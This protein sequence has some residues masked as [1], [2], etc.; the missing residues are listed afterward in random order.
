M[1][2]K[3]LSSLWEDW[4]TNK[5]G[6][7]I[8]TA[9][10]GVFTAVLLLLQIFFLK[11]DFDP[12][13]QMY[14]SS[15]TMPLLCGICFGGIALL[16]ATLLFPKGKFPFAEDSV[17]SHASVRA[18]NMA[19]ALACLFVAIR[20]FGN[21]S[22]LFD[23]MPVCILTQLM[24]LGSSVYFFLE[25]RKKEP[26]LVLRVVLGF[27]VI[28]MTALRVFSLYFDQS[29]PVLAPM[30]IWEL[31]G[32]LSV[33]LY[34]LCELRQWL[35]IPFPR[36]QQILSGVAV[37]TLGLSGVAQLLQ[38]L[39]EGG[40]SA[41]SLAFAILETALFCRL[42]LTQ[43]CILW[44]RAWD[45]ILNYLVFGVLTTVVNLVT[46]FLLAKT[47]G[48]H[49]LIANVIAWIVG[50]LFAYVVN[51]FL[52]FDA[53]ELALKQIG[54][55]FGL[56]TAARLLSL[57]AEE[58][59]LWIGVSLLSGSDLI[60]KIVA[61]VVVIIMNYVASKFVIFQKKKTEA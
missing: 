41:L 24:C 35:Q 32:M 37:I 61:A 19:C 15:S 55:E 49:F 28:L 16:F 33:C 22:Q 18:M 29:S 57:G 10:C 14:F 7:L 54:I 34:F 60:A 23:S 17:R 36:L 58:L 50:V 52:V 59:I 6:S 42:V 20:I 12:S 4:K 8:V 43:I 26:S 27:F 31:L 21:Q 13:Y 48:I 40:G 25:G 3:T 38:Y 46:Y 9:L 45:E 11:T 56:F 47:V 2:N 1:N 5:A 51:K 30:K 39:T 53:K 44:P